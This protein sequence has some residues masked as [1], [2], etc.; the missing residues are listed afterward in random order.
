MILAGTVIQS[1][2]PRVAKT[3]LL[4][5]MSDGEVCKRLLRPILGFGC[6]FNAGKRLPKTE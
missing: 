1:L 6:G 5:P 2:A 3:K 4:V